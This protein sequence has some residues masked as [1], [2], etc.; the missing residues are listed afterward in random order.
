MLLL[1][2]SSW[3]AEPAAFQCQALWVGPS[4][5]CALQGTWTGNGA[6]RSEKA[7]RKDAQEALV[8]AVGLAARAAAER[9][10]QT[11]AA[12]HLDLCPRV[13]TDAA[14][15]SC[16]PADGLAG[17]QLC[18]VDLVEDSCAFTDHF[19]IETYGFEAF[20]RGRKQM[21]RGMEK[22]VRA[23]QSDEPTIDDCLAA[24]EQHVRVRCPG[25]P[26]NNP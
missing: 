14:T 18:F 13:S 4:G 24:C 22:Q 8:D 2:L 23:A 19:T 7:A 1:V 20:E 16:I 5:E 11:M 12:P 17:F 26:A 10:K 25:I 3:A 21:C 9:T 6:G 15:V